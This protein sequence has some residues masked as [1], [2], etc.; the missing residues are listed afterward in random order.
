VLSVLGLWLWNL[1]PLLTIAVAAVIAVAVVSAVIHHFRQK[2]ADELFAE[3]WSAD[4]RRRAELQCEE[5]RQGAAGT[6]AGEADAEDEPPVSRY[7]AMGERLWYAVVRTGVLAGFLVI[8]D[9]IFHLP[10]WVGLVGMAVAFVLLALGWSPDE[11]EDDE[12]A[13]IEEEADD[14]EAADPKPKETPPVTEYHVPTALDR[15]D[16]PSGTTSAA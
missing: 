11:D 13:S 4:V 10:R 1:S 16:P 8:L 6:W 7:E 2:R 3:R 12:E 14:E 5:Y 15:P 9:R